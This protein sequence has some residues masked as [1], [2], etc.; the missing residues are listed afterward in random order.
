[1]NPEPP[2]T[3]T[4]VYTKDSTHLTLALTFLPDAIRVDLRLDGPPLISGAESQRFADWI[5]QI[6]VR[7]DSDPRPILMN[8]KNSGET[9][10]IQDLGGQTF[11]FVSKS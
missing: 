10:V 9:A 8:N 4:H 5:R 6:V 2:K 1:M 11:A 3:Q 7:F